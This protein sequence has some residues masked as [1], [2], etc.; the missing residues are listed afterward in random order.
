[1]LMIAFAY[2]RYSTFV[3]VQ[4]YPTSQSLDKSSS[5]DRGNSD[6]K[7]D[8]ARPEKNAVRCCTAPFYI[9]VGVGSGLKTNYNLAS[10]FKGGR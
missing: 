5:R 8:A 1:M 10:N 2:L 4:L 6:A 7:D 3:A 9:R